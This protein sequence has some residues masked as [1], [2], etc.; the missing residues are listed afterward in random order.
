MKRA[1]LFMII[2]L[3]QMAEIAVADGP[4]NE[5]RGSVQIARASDPEAVPRPVLD[6]VESAAIDSG[7]RMIFLPIYVPPSRSAPPVRSGGA[8]RGPL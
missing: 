5:T 1:V 4:A 6:G 3:V 2:T 8:T 7:T